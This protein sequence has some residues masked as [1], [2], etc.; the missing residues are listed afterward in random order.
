MKILLDQNLPR[1]AVRV[2]ERLGI[3]AVH[4][5]SVKLTGRPDQEVWRFA[6][7]NDRVIVTKDSDFTQI[8]DLTQK[9]SVRVVL[10][11]VGNTTNRVFFPWLLINWPRAQSLLDQGHSLIELI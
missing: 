7:E 8:L 10:L 11:K 6:A 2:F 3:D 4:V 1:S 9:K 5:G